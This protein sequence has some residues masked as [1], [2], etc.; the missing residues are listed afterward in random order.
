MLRPSKE[1]LQELLRILF[2]HMDPLGEQRSRSIL[3]DLR[4]YTFPQASGLT[5]PM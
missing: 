3:R 5:K 2:G 4:Q 1:P